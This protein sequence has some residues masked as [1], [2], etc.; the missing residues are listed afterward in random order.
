MIETIKTYL[1]EQR[2][3][4]IEELMQ[5]LRIPSISA[6]AEHQ[7]DMIRC[8]EWTA[9]SLKQAGLDNIEIMPTGGHP[10][11]YADWLHAPGKP[12]VLVYGHYDVQPAEPLELWNTPP[13]EPVIQDGKLFGR[14]STDDKGQLLLYAK[15]IE[16]F[17]RTHGQSTC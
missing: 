15:V 11:V 6:V 4:H 1:N 13:F 7:P 17:L 16:A 3:Q 8:A 14:G 12:T 10:V 5:F 2:D 9:Q